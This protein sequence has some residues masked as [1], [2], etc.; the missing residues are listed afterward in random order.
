MVAL[1]L[2][3]GLRSV[4]LKNIYGENLEL[5]T[6]LVHV[7]IVYMRTERVDELQSVR[8]EIFRLTADRDEL[9]KTILRTTQKKAPVD[10]AVCQF[11][12]ICESLISVSV[13]REDPAN[14]RS[15]AGAH[16]PP[17]R[18]RIHTR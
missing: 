10:A 18:K 16:C 11:S 1:I 9:A 12:T 13:P 2:A 5:A 14:Q 8:D 15:T 4:Q 3:T 7:Q 17:A 6:L